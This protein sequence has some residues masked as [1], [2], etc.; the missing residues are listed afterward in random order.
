MSLRDTLLCSVFALALPMGQVMFKWATIYNARL[1][2]SFLARAIQNWPLIGA[3]AWYAATALFWFYVLTR[4]PLS[5]AYAF[6]LV[7]SALVPIAAWALFK[8]PFSATMGAGY[9]L[10]LIGFLVVLSQVRA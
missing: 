7:G 3:F 2:G 6:S 8:E 10:I 4:V 9:A 1:E 5:Q